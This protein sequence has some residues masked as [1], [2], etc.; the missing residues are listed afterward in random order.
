MKILT[1]EVLDHVEG[2]LSE[3]RE[4]TLTDIEQQLFLLRSGQCGSIDEFFENLPL[5]T[6]EGPQVTRLTD[7]KELNPHQPP[8]VVGLFNVPLN[9]NIVPHLGKH[10]V[11]LFG[12]G[13][14]VPDVYMIPVI[15]DFFGVSTDYLLGHNDEKRQR[16]IEECI[17]QYRALWNEGKFEE[18]LRVMKSAAKKYPSE[19]PVTVRYLNTLI[20]CG[21]FSPERAVSVKN[22]VEA[23]YERINEFCTT[24]S[25]RIWAKKILCDFYL[26]LL[27]VE[28][29]GVTE[30]DIETILSE[31]PLMQ[32]CRDYLGGKYVSDP[33]EK[34][35]RYEACISELLFLLSK[36]TV[37]LC[38]EDTGLSPEERKKRLTAL[39]K[40]YEELVPDGSYGKSAENIAAAK[41]LLGQ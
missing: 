41:E 10:A 15:A 8:A 4:E 21:R 37:D 3:R 24:D 11:F 1:G 6:G 31:L 5:V 16:E 30:S 13:E 17:E 23:L 33:A 2:I 14:T 32:N 26:Y 19:Y 18:L 25:I 7:L 39:I 20:W 9:Q 28:N 12:V 35:E 36:R 40:A 29:S 38:R 27:N 22:E 34:A